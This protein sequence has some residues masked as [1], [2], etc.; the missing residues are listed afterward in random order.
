MKH[1]DKYLTER[2]HGFAAFT[3]I[4]DF[5][6]KATKAEKL[7]REQEIACA[8]QAKAKDAEAFERLIQSYLPVIASYLRRVGKE[9]QSMELL[10][11]LL[12]VLRRE[13][14]AFDFAQDSEPFMHRLSL[15]LKQAVTAYVADL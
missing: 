4:N 15:R 12:H 1:P 11:R 7:S 14:D 8:A 3:D 6:N 13:A 5:F 2:Y 9:M 10:Y